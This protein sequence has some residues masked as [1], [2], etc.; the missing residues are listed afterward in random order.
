[1]RPRKLGVLVC[2]ASYLPPRSL[3]IAWRIALCP[4]V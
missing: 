4:T 1:L 3:S 2:V